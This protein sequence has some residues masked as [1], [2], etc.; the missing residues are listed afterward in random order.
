MY[1]FIIEKNGVDLWESH[2]L[3]RNNINE[4]IGE[5]GEY[6]VKETETGLFTV[7]FEML[8]Y[9]FK[10]K[11][12]HDLLYLKMTETLSWFSYCQRKKVGCIIVNDRQIIS[13]GYNGTLPGI[14]NICE[15]ENGETCSDVVHAE[16]NAIMKLANNNGSSHGSHA[17]LNLS[18][19][20][21]CATLLIGS[22]VKRVVYSKP[23]SS[24]SELNRFS[25]LDFYLTYIDVNCRGAEEV[26]YMKI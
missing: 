22:G 9:K 24:L 13:H 19:C 5:A 21:D 12:K 23:H 14:K 1:E 18:P 4:L 7:E 25:E 20:V 11:V 2:M 8:P 6:A 16:K 10:K 15:D 17:Y 3:S 26:I